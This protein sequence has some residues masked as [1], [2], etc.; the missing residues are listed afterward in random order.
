MLSL[1]AAMATGF[2]RQT[3]L[4]A[5]LGASRPMDIFLVAYALP[6]FVYVALP[7]IL[8][9]VVIPLFMQ[10]SR[11]NSEAAAWHTAQRLGAWFLMGT[12]VIT[13]FAAWAAPMLITWLS[14]GF[15][16]AERL[17]A[18][19][20][21]YPML[22]GLLFMGIST[23]MGAL[24]Q[25]YRRFA[26][27]AL[28]TAVYNL[29]F[30]ACLLSLPLEDPLARAGFAVTLGALAALLFQLP[31]FLNVRRQISGSVSTGKVDLKPAFQLLG[32]MAAGYAVHHLILFVDRAMATN[33]GAGSAAIL[34]FGYHLA[35]TIG[36]VSGLAVST[37]LFPTL[38]KSI[39]AADLQAARRTLSQAMGL[40]L[41]LALPAGVGVIVLRQPVVQVLLEYGAF[42][43][44]DTQAVGLSL[45]IYTLA[46][47]ADALCQ[48][49]WRLVYA[50]KDGRVV[51]GVNGAQT[52]IRLAAN[53][54]LVK[55][56]GYNGLAISAV[57]GLSIQLLILGGL[58]YWRLGWR[59]TNP[60][61][62]WI[63]TITLTAG[64]AALVVFVLQAGSARMR[65]ELS[66]WITLLVG[67]TALMAVYGGVLFG[68]LRRPPYRKE[69][70]FFGKD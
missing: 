48:P 39:E 30:I 7:I 29:I 64:L 55:Y 2:L 4:A 22:P 10:I 17:H 67:G 6:E 16:T 41:A 21:F 43:A 19:A 32:W 38:S 37:V 5:T 14:P 26:R 8:S 62:R 18:V 3:A 42:T 53:L 52:V 27:P 57:I 33:Q 61:W 31:L 28:T 58:A 23:L 54:I 20:V 47:V 13:V 1:G 68:L 35:L 34:N 60:G 70:Y 56:F 49:L 69:G 50:W 45:A 12:L 65:L 63:S 40:V 46:I 59:I 11:Q 25:V 9:P 51:L 15:N 66:P 24:L 36:Q 44:Q